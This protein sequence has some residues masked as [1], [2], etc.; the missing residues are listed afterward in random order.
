LGFR[1]K[2]SINQTVKAAGCGFKG[3]PTGKNTSKPPYCYPIHPEAKRG[4]KAN[5]KF[6]CNKTGNH[7]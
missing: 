3:L 5:G 6:L 4:K 1:I 2:N 7:F